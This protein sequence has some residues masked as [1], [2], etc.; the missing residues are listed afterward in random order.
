MRRRALAQLESTRR[1]ETQKLA[2]PLRFQWFVGLAVLLLLLDAWL[3]DGGRLPRRRAAIPVT[4]LI[5]MLGLPAIAHAQRDGLAEAI[6]LHQA[7]RILPAVR[8]GEATLHPAT[9]HLLGVIKKLG[10]E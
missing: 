1:E 8:G 7:G 5:A 6:K 4:V 2:R 3:A 9:H 10:R